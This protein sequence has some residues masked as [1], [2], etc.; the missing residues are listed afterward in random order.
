MAATRHIWTITDGRAGNRAQALGLAE[1]FARALPARIAEHQISL[2][3]WAAWVPP[4]IS[5]RLRGVLGWPITGI[6]RGRA[7]LKPP[8]PDMI[9]GA[10]RR[11]APVVAALRQ[12]H[13]IKAVQVLSPQMPA[14][15]FDAVIVPSHDGLSGP[16]VIS[17]LGALNLLTAKKILDAATD[18]NEEFA[19]LPRPRI[20]VLI[21]GPSKSSGFGKFECDS[22][23]Q[24]LT[25]LKETDG[26][27][28]TPSR[29]TPDTLAHALGN[30]GPG[31]WTWDGSG[32]NPYPGL[33]GHTDAVLVTEESVNMASEA[34]TSGLPVHVFPVRQTAP[35]IKRFHQALSDQGATRP[36][37]GKIQTW[38]YQPL[39]E[40]DRI[41][42]D[43]IQ[44]GVVP[45]NT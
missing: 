7:Y 20:A 2:K 34:A 24:T 41:V 45:Q 5:W 10:G 37:S 6:G 39:A 27:I 17:S 32:A 30:L 11:S 4:A 40:A 44:R 21:G 3:P 42:A 15:A 31:T 22:L 35:K 8:W 25:S 13:G 1:A 36:F 26:L 14:D 9:I 16:N 33:L 29:R 43:L 18:W 23:I 19:D 38:D 12:F 28:I